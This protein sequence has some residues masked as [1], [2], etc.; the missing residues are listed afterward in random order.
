[1]TR[2]KAVKI[3][4]E[5]HAAVAEL[6]ALVRQVGVGAL[7]A[8]AQAALAGGVNAGTL[9]VAGLALLRE[10]VTAGRSRRR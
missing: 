8:P 7:S 6:V 2:Y 5:D 10:Q 4:E 3:R 9:V 1:M